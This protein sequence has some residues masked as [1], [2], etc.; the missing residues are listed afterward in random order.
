[1]KFQS[2]VSPVCPAELQ[3]CAAMTREALLQPSDPQRNCI[4]LLAQTTLELG[5]VPTHHSPLSKAGAGRGH[6][7]CI[8]A[9]LPGST[10][11]LCPALPR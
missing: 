11:A 7:A 9:R 10:F 3:S 1:M 4:R 5:A 8:P 6:R 2:P